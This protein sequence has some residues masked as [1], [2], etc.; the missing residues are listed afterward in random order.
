MSRWASSLAFLALITVPACSGGAPAGPKPES[1]AT[2]ASGPTQAAETAPAVRGPRFLKAPADV[3]VAEHMATQVEEADAAGED[4]LLYVGAEWCEP[5]QTF[6]DAV[7]AG[8]LDEV[9]P[10]LRLVEYDLDVDADR[11]KKADYASRYI[12]LFTVPGP[13]GYSSGRQVEGAIK[14]DGA[15][16]HILKRLVPL[17]EAGRKLRNTGR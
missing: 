6:H 14:G 2:E 10:N 4:I 15:V 5:C 12:P 7:E 16:K 11:L 3:P 9:L 8:E 13:D 1:R 17:I